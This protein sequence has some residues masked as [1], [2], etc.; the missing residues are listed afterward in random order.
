MREPSRGELLRENSHVW[1]LPLAV[2]LCILSSLTL[3]ME[4]PIIPVLI[5]GALCAVALLLKPFAILCIVVSLVGLEAINAI[6]PSP[7]YSLT[8]I[9]V[10]GFLLVASL[11][12]R[13]SMGRIKFR[14][15]FMIFMV[16]ALLMW[17]IT[18]MLKAQDPSLAMR[19][20]LTIGQLTVL[21]LA[22]RLLVRKLHRLEII[23]VIAMLTMSVSA[24]IGIREFIIDPAARISGTSQNAAVLSADLFVAV[25]LGLALFKTA[26]SYFGKSVWGILIAICASG[27]L[28][29][30][31][32]AAYLAVIP[33]IIVAGIYMGKTRKA[34]LLLIIIIIAVIILA[35]FTVRRLSETSLRDDPSTQ[36]HLLSLWAGARMMADNPFLGVGIGNYQLHYLRY[37][38]DVRMLPRTPHNSYLAFG[39]ETGVPGLLLF[40]FII[41]FA[42]HYLWKTSKTLR[43]KKDNL[44]LIYVTAVAGALTA[45]CVIGLFHALHV[46]KYLWI[47]LGLASQFPI[48]RRLNHQ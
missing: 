41:G 48:Q 2:I 44:S 31:S 35:P 34:L 14:I 22:I 19:S 15:D 5:I 29:S 33:S 7:V 25:W 8:A 20:F 12:I 30:L 11:I 13:I 40:L 27:I 9:K 47:L 21:W 46:S 24:I 38:Q 10:A 42:Y 32:R 39:S 45:F 17:S 4:G 23:S 6:R 18:S 26:R 28:F 1:L 36:G 16:A 37:T 43:K 3:V